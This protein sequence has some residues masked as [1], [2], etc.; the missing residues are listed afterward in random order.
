MSNSLSL[1]AHQAIRP[2]RS[3]LC[4]VLLKGWL[5]STVIGCA[6]KYGQSFLV[7]TLRANVACSRRVYQVSTSDRDLLI[8]N[9][10]FCC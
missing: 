9:M 2:D 3:G 10:G 8:K 7:A 5:V 6:W 1:I 4:I